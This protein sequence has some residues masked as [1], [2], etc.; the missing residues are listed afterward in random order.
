M[1]S[2]G[3]GLAIFAIIEGNHYGWWSQRAAFQAGSLTWPREWVAITPLLFVTSAALLIAFWRHQER[4][5]AKNKP[6]LIDLSL[7]KVPA[8]RHG[9][10]AAMI[11]SLG[12]LGLV[13]IL[14]LYLQTV[15]DYSA[16]DT[17]VLLLALSLGAFA[18]GGSAAK[19]TYRIGARR[20]VIV[21]FAL[22]VVGILGLSL[23]SSTS[24]TAVSMAPLLAVYGLGV[25]FA[26]AQLTSIVL[27]DIP[28][29]DSGLA[30]GLQST[31]RQL[32]AA[33]GIAILGSLFVFVVM[34]RTQ[35]RLA[36]YPAVSASSTEKVVK[37]ITRTGGA[38]SGTD[39]I[40]DAQRP[41]ADAAV[42]LAIVDAAR[43][44]AFAAAMFVLL[45]LIAALRLPRDDHE[46]LPQSQNPQIAAATPGKSNAGA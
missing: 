2:T 20:V 10:F 40:P 42:N 33:L 4:R 12:E 30:S 39:D 29:R 19:L 26:T 11:V 7:Y 1:S 21:G 8:F 22:E 44:T 9:N 23:V 25:G 18:A 27:R 15:L 31:T 41:S 35:S 6:I 37:S 46:L 32:G 34:E 45:G 36:D 17:G 24:T 16:F 14:P 38:V 43:I 5:A 13:F 3:I 28:T